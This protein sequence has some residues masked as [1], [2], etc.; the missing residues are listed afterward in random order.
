[1]LCKKPGRVPRRAFCVGFATVPACSPPEKTVLIDDHIMFT[2]SDHGHFPCYFP[3]I[4]CYFAAVFDRSAGFTGLFG[5]FASL[6][7]PLYRD[8]ECTIRLIHPT[9]P[10]FE[11]PTR[12]LAAC[13]A[14]ATPNAVCVAHFRQTW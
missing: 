8:L 11:V 12:R 13:S 2:G 4:P 1:K 6:P 3:V 5:I 10:S 14:R 7:A 9:N